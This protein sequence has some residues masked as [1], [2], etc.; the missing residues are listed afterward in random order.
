MFTLQTQHDFSASESI[1]SHYN[2]SVG[3]ANKIYLTEYSNSYSGTTYLKKS[4]SVV[5]RQ[6]MF[7]FSGL[8][9]KIQCKTSK[10][11]LIL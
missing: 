10:I 8:I 7:S 2:F 11:F 1:K 5:D 4:S 3:R 6:Y 9:R